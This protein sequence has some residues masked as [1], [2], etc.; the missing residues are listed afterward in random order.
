MAYSIREELVDAMADYLE[1]GNTASYSI[2]RISEEIDER[3]EGLT[4][5]DILDGF[6]EVYLC[7]PQAFEQN[8]KDDS[9]WLS[10]NE[11]DEIY[12]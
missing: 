10:S 11:S 12:D 4:T 6:L 1:D 8:L 2:D 7:T 5:Q 3:G 9:D